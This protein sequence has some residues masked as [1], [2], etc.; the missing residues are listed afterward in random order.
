MS[1][2]PPRLKECEE[3]VEDGD[4]LQWRE[5]NPQWVDRRL[6]ARDAFVGAGGFTEEVSTARA[7][8]VTAA[9]AHVHFVEVLGLQSIGTWA[10]TVA[11]VQLT[12]ARVV[13]DADCDDVEI[14]GHSYIDL[15]GMTRSQKREARAQLAAFATSRG[16]CFPISE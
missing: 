9:V 11:E 3:L 5:V 7:S 4:E 16:R 12:G 1:S 10:V 8:V 14:P 2:T 13:D 6:V 15:R